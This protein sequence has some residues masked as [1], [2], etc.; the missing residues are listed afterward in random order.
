M[1]VTLDVETLPDMREG[2]RE[3]FIEDARQN[4]KAPSDLTKEKAL[5]EL[6]LKDL[7]AVSLAKQEELIYHTPGEEPLRLDF[8][9][10]ALRLL[11]RVRDESHRFA[12]ESHRASRSARLRRSVLEEVPGIGRHRAA[13]LLGRFGSVRNMAAMSA[14]E[15]ATVPGI[16]PAMA[17]RIL[18]VL[19]ENIGGTEPEK[20]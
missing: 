15:L 11:Q 2:A 18:S 19:K 16:G 17:E 20:N 10:S 1:Q 8:G 6:G 3:A 9:D 13:Q 12:I 4:V 14:E 5:D 7:P